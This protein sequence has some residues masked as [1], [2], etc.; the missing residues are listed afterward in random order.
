[1]KPMNVLAACELPKLSR[2]DIVFDETLLE[3]LRFVWI[4]AFRNREKRR[5]ALRIFRSLEIA[6]LASRLPAQG[7]G[8]PTIHDVG[9]SLG[10]WVSAFE[11]LCHPCIGDVHQSNV[12]DEVVRFPWQGPKTR[13]RRYTVKIGKKRP[14]IR[15]CLLAQ[16]VTNDLYRARNDFL[17]GN[18]VSERNLYP[19]K[20]SKSLMLL[21][22]APLIYRVLLSVQLSRFAFPR[23][24]KLDFQID[25]ARAT[26]DIEDAIAASIA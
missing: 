21:Y 2:E 25:E 9:A 26:L 7:S 17:H 1:V 5:S 10:L 11:I 22:S 4:R 24:T 14:P 13:S 23:R 19:R 8:L 18:R 16:R 6:F 12:L 15:G 3:Q 20:N